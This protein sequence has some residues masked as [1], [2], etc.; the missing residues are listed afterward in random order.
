MIR[1]ILVPLDGSTFGEHALPLA[2]TMAKRLDASLNLIHV[3]SLLD[4]TYAELQV[5][6][7]TLDQ[8]LRNKEREYLHTVQKQL[9][10]RL[11]VPVTIRNVDGDMPAVVR[12]QADS[13]RA[14]WV[15]MTTHA[16]GPMG[17]FW[18][19][20]NTDE[21]IRTLPIPLIA[22]HPGGD[23]PDL[24][25]EYRVQHML[26]PLDGTPFG[27]D[28]L[29]STT[30][31]A[32]VM[33]ADL[34]LLRVVTPV[35]PVTLPAEPAIFGSVAT[36]IMDRVEKMHADLRK[37]ASAYLETIANRLRADGLKV[38]TRVS[39]DEQPGIAILEAA[40]PP[41]DMIAI[42]THGRGG[43]SRLLLGSTADKVIRGSPLPILVHRP[44]G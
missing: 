7:N 18:L 19:G 31:F 2:M 37:D 11:S 21:L 27:E 40:K 13:L 10:D 42:E 28:I 30:S 22:V 23:A 44:K 17:R 14:S 8:E 24:S 25:K 39:V 4:A 16:R 3:H 20:S 5:F 9:Q 34:T 43:L 35:Y 32:K 6:D 38:Q 26:V 41:I 29:E 36:D 33:G 15:V 1:S 12:E